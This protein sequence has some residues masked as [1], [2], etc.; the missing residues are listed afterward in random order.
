MPL[1]VGIV[2]EDSPMRDDVPLE[3]IIADS[4]VSETEPLLMS[5]STQ[6]SDVNTIFV[7]RRLWKVSKLHTPIDWDANIIV[8]ARNIGNIVNMWVI[9]LPVENM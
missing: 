7:N 6:H 8:N 1:H 3:P 9:R 2:N 5:Q 4:V